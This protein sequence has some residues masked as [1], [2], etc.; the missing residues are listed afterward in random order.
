LAAAHHGLS[1]PWRAAPPCW[2]WTS[3]RQ[4]QGIFRAES[5]CRTANRWR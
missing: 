3:W 4:P 2:W 1:V 5:G